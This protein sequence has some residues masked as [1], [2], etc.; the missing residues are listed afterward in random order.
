MKDER[1]DDDREERDAA[2]DAAKARENAEHDEAKAREARRAERDAERAARHAER[3]ARRAE[4]MSHK[5]QFKSG[6]GGGFTLDGSEFDP[7]QFARAFVGDFVGD[8]GGESYSDTVEERFTFDKTPRVRVRNVS[9]ETSITAAGAPGEIRVLAR[10]RVSASSEDRAKRLLQNLEV[11]MEKHGDELLVEP[12][13]YEQE[14]GWLDLFR[15]KRFRVDFEIT[16]P[17]ECAIDAQTVSGELSV[18]GVRGPLEIQTVSGDVR[19]EDVQGPMRLKSVSGDLDCRR[20][21]GHLEGNTVSGDV[22]IV[23]A[24]LRSS[25]LHTVSGDVQIEG[26][27]DPRKEHRFKTISGDIELALAEPDVTIEYRSASGDIECELPARIVKRGRKDYSVVIGGGLGHVGVKTV[28]GDLTVRGT[29]AAAPDDARPEETAPEEA[30]TADSDVERTLP[31]DR[32]SREEVRSVLERLARG[33]LGVDDA[34]AALD[35]ARRGH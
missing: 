15:G 27:L 29:S 32:S 23:A 2:K 9:G 1:R 5:F 8:V 3:A 6:R 10:K 30:A 31:M 7:G 34:A 19:L 14:R 22:T 4:H 35:E 26:R 24:R 16:V 21:V 11:R 20:Y 12:H 17:A 28:S 18:E 33:E 13:L 25:Q